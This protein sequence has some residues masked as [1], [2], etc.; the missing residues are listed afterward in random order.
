MQIIQA[1]QDSQLVAVADIDAAARS[2]VEAPALYETLT[3]LMA[4]SGTEVDV[5]SVCT[6]N[7]THVALA[8]EAVRAGKHVVLEKPMGLEVEGVEALRA[9]AQA[10][11]V[12]VFGVMQNRYA[13]AAQ[14]MK[15][16]ME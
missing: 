6:P 12:T 2:S 11:G 14:W 4:K 5:V 15:R 3:D 10:H 7:G 9:E 13:P 16:A 8:I 1:R